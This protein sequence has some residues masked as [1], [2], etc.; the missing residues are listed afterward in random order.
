MFSHLPSSG[1]VVRF[2]V[3]DPVASPEVLFVGVQ[4]KVFSEYVG[5]VKTLHHGVDEARVA[6]VTKPHHCR[7]LVRIEQD[8][9]VF[10]GWRSDHWG[11]GRGVGSLSAGVLSNAVRTR[12]VVVATGGVVRACWGRD[13]G[14]HRWA[15]RL[16]SRG[17]APHEG[18]HP[19]QVASLGLHG[20]GTTGVTASPIQAVLPVF[21]PTIIGWGVF[22][23]NSF[24]G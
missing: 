21:S 14:Q 9:I 13:E 17:D 24:L 16:N 22:S 1:A 12:S 15:D 18:T 3:A 2:P 20:G 4:D 11:G 23:S 8:V 5:V 7:Y 10:H 19:R 6:M